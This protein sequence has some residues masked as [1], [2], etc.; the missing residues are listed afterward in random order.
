MMVMNDNT[1]GEAAKPLDMLCADFA[2]AVCKAFTEKCVETTI[3]DFD[4]LYR[5]R[6]NTRGID[7]RMVYMHLDADRH[8]LNVGQSTKGL[9]RRR[10][11]D[12]GARQKKP[13]YEKVA[14]IQYMDGSELSDDQLELIERALIVWYHPTG[15]PG[16][17]R[18][19]KDLHNGC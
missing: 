3:S 18:K 11:D 14:S 6:K 12:G 1:L 16:R 15:N 2:E 9:R 10:T 4:S 17:R 13:W 8:V 7:N 5:K 19:R